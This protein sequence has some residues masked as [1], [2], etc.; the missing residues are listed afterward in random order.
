MLRLSSGKGPVESIA[1]DHVEKP[2]ENVP[3][4]NTGI[5]KGI[6][7]MTIDHPA[8][9]LNRSRTLLLLNAAWMA[10]S[11]QILLAQVTAM[12]NLPPAYTTT[13]NRASPAPG[14]RR[15]RPTSEHTPHRGWFQMKHLASVALLL[16]ATLFAA[17][18]FAQ[19]SNTFLMGPL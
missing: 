17:R 5:R 9:R 10:F 14:A 4:R 6:L 13:R 3:R 16:T 15:I 2:S 8:H 11:G 7:R 12:P 19:T 18:L 1:I